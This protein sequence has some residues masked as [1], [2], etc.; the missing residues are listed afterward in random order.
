MK[1]KISSLLLLS[2][3]CLAAA[4][5]AGED[6]SKS[7][8]K[9]PIQKPPYVPRFYVSLSAGGEFDIHATKFISNGGGD[10]GFP[11][12]SLPVKIQSRDFTA[13]HD[14]AVINGN[15]E[16]GYQINSFLTVFAGFTYSHADGDSHGVGR[17]D[18]PSG[19]FGPLGG[20]YEL[21]ADV[22]K[23]QAYTG[24]LGLKANLPRTLL[25]IIHAPKIITPY[26][27]ASAGGKYI[28]SQ[29]AN[30]YAPGTGYNSNV[31]L[32]EDSFVFTT[33]VTF[34]YDIAFTPNFSLVFESGY[35][36]DT[37]PE[38][39]NGLPGTTGVNDGGD[40]LY[41]TVSL[42]AKVKF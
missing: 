39:G 14:P 13:T 29:H 28:E 36:Y 24:K 31:E 32:Y 12:T 1:N 30:F 20:I 10:V 6:Y 40:R 41:S 23:Y 17:L 35:G 37:K 26:L 33:Q 38:R 15:L 34:G 19:F 18:D 16:V 5:H 4:S 25:D 9:N 22:S 11:G 8:N 42:G 2:T 21:K 3:V 7:S 27:S